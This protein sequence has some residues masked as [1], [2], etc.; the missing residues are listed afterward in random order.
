VPTLEIWDYSANP[1]DVCVGIDHRDA[2]LQIGRY[3]VELGYR[4][5][6]FVG[7][8]KGQDQR[9]DARLDGIRRAFDELQ[10]PVFVPAQRPEGLKSFEAGFDGTLNLLNHFT[11]D[12]V[13]YLNDHMAFGG[14]MAAE[15]RSLSVPDDLGV[16]G[17]NRLDITNVL[18]VT[19]T[20]V[21]TPRRLMGIMGA[22][23]LLARIHGVKTD[24]AVALP[25]EIIKGETTRSQL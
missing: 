2:G 18:P 22:R 14:M 23:A 1:I 12:V 20:T 6:A 24:R 17:F 4:K 9:A 7:V 5:P 16:V 13:F 3:A 11:P 8:S 15:K 10:T 19:L 25:V 21:V